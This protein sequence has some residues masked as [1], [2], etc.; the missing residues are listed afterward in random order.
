M[1][2][3]MC[4]TFVLAVPAVVAQGQQPRTPS[5][6]I[7][8]ASRL[9]L[10]GQTMKA[11]VIL[12]QV[13]DTI[14]DPAAKADAQRA[15][16]MSFAFAGD[17]ANTTKYESLVID[18]WRSRERADPGNAYYQ[19]GEMADEAARVCLD[20]NDMDTAERW[21]RKG[22]ELGLL[23]PAP[24]TH[25]R[26]LWDF[27]LAHAL[28]RIAAR[29]GDTAQAHRE[30]EAARH[31]LDADT[32]MAAQQERFF[33][34][35]VGYVALYT[36]DLPTAQAQFT[37]AIALKG[38]E[39]DPY[40]RCLLAMTDEQLNRHDD[41]MAQYRDAYDLATAHNPGSAFARRYARVKLDLPDT[42]D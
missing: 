3:V 40:L 26:A 35:L 34:Y 20:A 38:N 13:L 29:R 9:D 37:K 17:C 7:R 14:S 33:P 1:R 28:G 36:N 12:R 6:Q 24:Q 4:G 5:P 15:M 39:K 22:Y 2:S 42:T 11:R 10:D 8:E 27:R 30:I 41:A 16:A 23:E 32:A 21:Y 19:E 18:Y 25:R 31:A